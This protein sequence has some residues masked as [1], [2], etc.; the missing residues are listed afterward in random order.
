MTL[1][2]G[3]AVIRFLAWLDRHENL[4]V[5]AAFA[6]GDPVRLRGLDFVEVVN[7][8]RRHLETA[9]DAASAEGEN[10]TWETYKAIREV[11]AASMA[12]DAWQEG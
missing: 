10:D 11:H 3:A 8:Y 4:Q 2:E 1:D 9:E 6:D 5:V 7:E 12:I